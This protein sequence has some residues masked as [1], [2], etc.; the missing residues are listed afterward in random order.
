MPA[1]QKKTYCKFHHK[2]HHVFFIKQIKEIQI[3]NLKIIKK[4]INKI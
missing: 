3:I 4:N 1:Q 2:F